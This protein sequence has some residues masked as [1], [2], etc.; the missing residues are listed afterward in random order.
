MRAPSRGCRLIWRG[1]TTTTSMGRRASEKPGDCN[2]LAWSNRRRG[3]GFGSLYFDT[4]HGI[5][6]R[7]VTFAASS[8]EYCAIA[9]FAK[10]GNGRTKWDGGRSGTGGRRGTRKLPGDVSDG[11]RSW[12]VIPNE[13]QT[14][15]PVSDADLMPA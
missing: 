8:T 12:A 13:N 2:P 15:I 10:R 9:S 1:T 4:L 3:T 11:G 14:I 7:A 6:R 5:P